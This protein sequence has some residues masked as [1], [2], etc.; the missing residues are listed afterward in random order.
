MMT[1]FELIF[2]L[3]FFL[4]VCTY[5]VHEIMQVRRNGTMRVNQPVLPRLPILRQICQLWWLIGIYPEHRVEITK[6]GRPILYRFL[7][8]G[9]GFVLFCFTFGALM[10]LVQLWSALTA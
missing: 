6:A 4:G 2:A 5:L 8:V 9:L 1:I 10:I 3:L 7:V